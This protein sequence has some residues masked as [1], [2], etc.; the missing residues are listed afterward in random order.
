MWYPVRQPL[1]FPPMPQVSCEVTPGMWEGSPGSARWPAT[2][3]RGLGW[4]Q[5]Q[6]APPP[7]A[8]SLGRQ[9]RG[10]A[11]PSTRFELS[12]RAASW[13]PPVAIGPTTVVAPRLQSYCVP[14]VASAA[15]AISPSPARPNCTVLSNELLAE[16]LTGALQAC[17][18]AREREVIRPRSPDLTASWDEALADRNE[19]TQEW[20]KLQRD[21][22]EAREEFTARQCAG[23]KETMKEINDALGWRRGLAGKGKH[24]EL[25]GGVTQRSL[26]PPQDCEA[27]P[28]SASVPLDCRAQES[29]GTVGTATGKSVA[30]VCDAPSPSVPWKRRLR[31]RGKS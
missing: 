12:P 25:S 7:P 20:R 15:G 24:T 26:P 10:D 17:G 16:R 23:L 8:P 2:S 22:V 6:I 19:L 4:S 11:S 30:I 13:A 27:Y 28:L 9:W 29:D 14:S 5:F 21:L 1:L 3:P 18:T 31:G